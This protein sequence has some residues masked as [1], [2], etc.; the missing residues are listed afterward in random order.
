VPARKRQFGPP[1][2]AAQA[3][4]GRPL[5]GAVP[6][7]VRVRGQPAVAGRA[8]TDAGRRG[9]LARARVRGRSRAGSPDR[10][11]LRRGRRRPRRAYLPRSLPVPGPHRTGAVRPAAYRG[12]GPARGARDHRVVPAHQGRRGTGGAGQRG[13]AVH[14]L[15]DG[16]G[17]LGGHVPAGAGHGRP[18]DARR[19]QPVVGHLRRGD[20]AG[21][22]RLARP[23]HALPD[24]QP[25][26][27]VRPF[28]GQAAQPGPARR[29]HERAGG[30]RPHGAGHASRAGQRG[31]RGASDPD[32]RL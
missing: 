10:A 1:V 25:V 19:T 24:G 21:G 16:P 9:G 13:Q 20:A 14:R 15:L 11:F 29:D 30:D 27:G 8:G 4:P 18:G 5:P 12:P 23:A 2:A 32:R 31:H 17:R 3:P 22:V 7:P 28:R 6:G 26:P